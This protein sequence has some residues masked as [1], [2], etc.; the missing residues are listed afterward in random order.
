[1]STRVRALLQHAA[2]AVVAYV[3]LLLTAPGRV[4]ADTK[5]YLYLDPSKL[6]SRAVSMWDPD[7][8]LGT[9][10]HQTIGYLWPM[11]PWFWVFDK[12][13]VPDWMAQRL[14]VGTLL[15]AAGAGVLYLL[16]TLGT[17]RRN[18]VGAVAAALV[19][20][21]SP[22][23]LHYAAR[24]S[25]LLLPWAALPWLVALTERTLR[26]RSWRHPAAFALLVAT[27][28]GVNA[29][30]LVLAGL[31]PLLWIPFA[32]WVH[33]DATWRQGLTATW[34]IG[35][36]TVVCSLWWIAGLAIQG[37]YGI[38]ILRYTETV[39]TVA[40][41]SLSSE[42]LRGLGY[43]FFY[44]GDKLGSW[45][46]PGRS[47]TQHLW[48][49]AIGFVVPAAALLAAVAIRWRYRAFAVTMVL[50]GTAVAVGAYPY[51]AP[52]PVGALFK[53][54]ARS[55]TAGLALRSTP[56]AI[57]LVTL[58]LALLVA[59][60]LAAL[61]AR[62]PRA[63]VGCA[64]ALAVVAAIGIPPLWTGDFIGENLQRPED[65][66]RYWKD[67]A[68]FLDA[69]GDSTRVLEIPGADF[70][71]YR[72]GNTVDPILPGMMDRPYAAR[73][74]IPYGSEASADLL[75]ALDRRMQEGVLETSA[76][77]PVARLMGVGDVVVR[78]DLQYERYR[79]PRPLTLWNLLTNPIPAGLGKPKGFGKAMPN[80][81]IAKLP[82][83]DEIFLATP[84][85]TPN[86]PPVSAFPVTDPLPIVRSRDAKG[87]LLVAGDGEGVVEAASAGL[88]GGDQVLLYSA[89]L[90]KQP[91]VRKQALAD[92][93]TLLLTDTNRKRARR[94]STVRENTGYTERAG[95]KPLVDD[96]SDNR[97]PLFPDA[98]D[99]AYTTVEQRG[100]ASVQA[101]DYGNPVSY[102]AEDRPANAFDG[103]TTTAWR[104][105]AFDAVQ[106][107]RLVLTTKGKVTTDH[108]NVVQPLT[109][110]R[111]RFITRLAV[112][113][114]GK[115]VGTFDLGDPS[116]TDAGQDLSL[117]RSR[118]FSKLTLTIEG[119]NVGKRALY[120][121][122]SGVGLSEVRVA[123]V[124]LDEVV[125]LPTDLLSTAGKASADHP[126][127]ILL[128][129]L[130]ANPQELVRSDE[131]RSMRRTFTLPTARQFALTGEARISA[132]VPDE[133]VDRLLGATGPAARSSRHLAGDLASRASS[134]VDG[135]KATAW[136]S[137]F[138]GQ[139]G[140]WVDVDVPDRPI[141]HLNLTLVAD[142]FHSVPTRVVVT[143]ERGDR[144][145]VDVP[146][147]K[148]GD[149]RGATADVVVTFPVVQGTTL[150]VTVDAV[151]PT[152]TTDWFSGEKL[153]MPVAIAE[154]GIPGFALAPAT[155]ISTTCRSDLLT[156]DGRPVPLS[157]SGTATDA[158]GRL[159][160][161]VHTCG[162]PVQLGAGAHDL[163]AAPGLETGYDLDRLVLSS[164]AGGLAAGPPA[165]TEPSAAAPK[166]KVQSSGHTSF[167]LKVTGATAASWLVLG[168]SNSK[169]WHATVKG[170]GDLGEPQIVDGYANGWRLPGTKSGAYT[171]HLRWTPQ[172]EVWA[173]LYLSLAGALLCLAI[174]AMAMWRRYGSA[175]TGD[176]VLPEE[177]VVRIGPVADEPSL[178][179]PWWATGPPAEPL[180]AAVAAVFTGLAAAVVVHPLFGLGIAVATVLALRLPRG[181]LVGLG[182]PV[183]VGLTALFTVVK[184]WRNGYPPD[185]GWADF[186]RPAHY[187]AWG[188]L[189]LVLVLLLTDRVRRSTD[190]SQGRPLDA[191]RD[192]PS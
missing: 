36:L 121:G 116:R 94:W 117:G 177:V 160:L 157:I 185:F 50:L 28:G 154:L 174:V 115:K 101:S 118:T 18:A 120:D 67:A 103:D 108:V 165:T 13:G 85:S 183:L 76:L 109:G 125:K 54:F 6:L 56:R 113:L 15:F 71:S 29:T 102:T 112:S 30:A 19:Y 167:D 132:A 146:A 114:D 90:A 11:G 14:W 64:I 151:R 107:E 21:L 170:G 127:T 62:R 84:A 9:V 59:A 159:A 138:G 33:R 87:T 128:S 44:G 53:A 172:R 99:D 136:T 147:V 150:R 16:R 81:A 34:R 104:T 10:T 51:P 135:N 96:P 184:Q 72:W 57:P 8:G 163:R 12:L 180:H 119:D 7:V 86:P 2:L 42:V 189:W 152:V 168:Q 37:A 171:V 25:V 145:V 173:A 155:T 89:A 3:P 161:Q 39:E 77:G 45:I 31:G 55:S 48:L 149:H 143:T 134:A 65:V 162:E 22:Y 83:R 41:T 130:R 24:I 38:D 17:S 166:V 26:T 27:A 66:P 129:R 126:L 142:G 79:T 78:S 175:I 100:V 98:K 110:P 82:L 92:G 74:L 111:N 91:K 46:E 178:R 4:A 63:S 52:S 144:Q 105:G 80:N 69:K 70:A 106:G 122:F 32:V 23:V 43:W 133:Q 169:G 97:L 188:A 139:V 40:R 158:V 131:E 61:A 141:D 60:G 137:G 182:G 58:G 176:D 140:D 153:D 192:D 191:H 49:I 5:T 164:A 35:V 47:Y 186:F 68:A 187:L 93:A 148:D 73:E 123:G 124:H 190:K 88:L 181:R 75:A 20:A 179:D 95:E 1:M 156:V